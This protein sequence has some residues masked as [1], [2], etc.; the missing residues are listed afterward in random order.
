MVRGGDGLAE[1]IGAK[2]PSRT[3]KSNLPDDVR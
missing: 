1:V 3:R 2:D